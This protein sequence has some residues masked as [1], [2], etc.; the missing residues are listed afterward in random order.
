M[1]NETYSFMGFVG[2]IGFICTILP[3]I[4]GTVYSAEAWPLLFPLLFLLMFL[5]GLVGLGDE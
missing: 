3:A 2:L 1:T 5:V 4:A